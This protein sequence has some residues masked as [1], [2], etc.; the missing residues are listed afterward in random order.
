MNWTVVVNPHAGTSRTDPASIEAALV[1]RGVAGTV[2]AT[3]GVEALDAV[4]R[5]VMAAGDP[6]VAVVGGDG[7]LHHAVNALL[8]VEGATPP[9]I[10]L[11][12]DG[13]GSDFARTFGQ[14]NDLGAALD[15]LARPNRYTVDVCTISGSF[16]SRYFLNAANAGIAAASVATAERMPS[17]L[18]SMRYRVGFWASLAPFHRAEIEVTIDR[19]RFSGEAINVAVANGQYFGGGLNIAP[20]ATLVDGI[21]DV[22]VFSG[23]KRNA[24]VIMP[25]LAFGAHLTHRA[26]RRYVGRE[27][28]IT[29]PDDWPIEADGELLGSGSVVISVRPGA[30]DY[31]V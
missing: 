7:T 25:R 21:V 12:P 30:L 10:A 9:T 20:R 5:D 28:T 13:S 6:H 4:A 17:R 22:Q 26:V 16:G 11:I 18:G 23:P 8:S 3:D 1:A 31:V 2:V 19:H 24:F 14:T 15:R 29:V 27:I